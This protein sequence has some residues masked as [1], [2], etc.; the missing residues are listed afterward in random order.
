MLKKAFRG[1]FFGIS[2]ATVAVCPESSLFAQKNNF[3]ENQN[4]AKSEKKS[5]ILRLEIEAKENLLIVGV[6]SKITITAHFKDGSPPQ[7]ITSIAKIKPSADLEIENGVI[8]ARKAGFHTLNASHERIFASAA[9]YAKNETP[10]TSVK[11]SNKA[12]KAT[13]RS[14]SKIDTFI[15]ENLEICEVEP[16]EKCSDGEFLRRLYL[17]ATGLLPDAKTAEDFLKSQDKTKREKAV[18]KV[19]GSPEFLDMLSMRL[20]DV[21]RI[22][23]EFPSNLWPNAA[24]AYHTWIRDSL[25]SGVPYDILAREMLLSSGSNFKNPPVNFY[26]AVNEKNAENFAEAAALVFMGVR[27][28]CVKCHPHP[29][30][31]WTEEDGKKF[32]AIFKHLSFKKSKEWKE[33]ILTF[34]IPGKNPQEFQIFG[35]KITSEVGKDPREAFVKWLTDEKNPYFAKIAVNRIWHWIFGAGITNPADDLRPNKIS[36][37]PKLEKYLEDVFVKSGYDLKAVFKEIFLSDAYSRSSRTN[38]SNAND[39][40]LFS[41]H[42]PARLDAES[43]NDIISG[44]FGV[45]QPFKSITPEP[46]AFWPEDFRAIQLHDGSVSNPFLTLFGKP[47]RNS[48]HLNDRS[49]KL[50]MQQILHLLGSSNINSK[51]DKSQFLKDLAKQPI[52]PHKKIT[53]LYLTFLTRFPTQKELDAS[54]KYLEENAKTTY[55]GL[56]DIAWALINTK[57]FLFKL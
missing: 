1:I 8:T 51:L 14:P 22:K 53:T 32:A 30:E 17:D 25:E 38:P 43:L 34:D 54:K 7:D 45:Y 39:D 47:G 28:N 33:E 44:I 23:S 31:S 18:N 56:K 24:Q 37:N 15:N 49:N 57:E 19:M 48:S 21:L 11:K 50:S 3:S 4:D 55:E 5:N 2:M 29:E 41:R 35:E 27:T 36:S 26:R 52:P 16:S 46:Y 13:P 40:T 20:S 12:K 42:I 9:F 6:P 10:K